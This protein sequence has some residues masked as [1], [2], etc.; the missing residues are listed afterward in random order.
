MLHYRHLKAGRRIE[1]DYLNN[2][3][4]KEGEKHEKENF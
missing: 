4:K 1:I 2:K 3:I